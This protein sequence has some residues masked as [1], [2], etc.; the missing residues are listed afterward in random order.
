[1]KYS[2]RKGAQVSSAHLPL[3]LKYSYEM[4]AVSGSEATAQ[5]CPFH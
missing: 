2:V 1:M 4:A 3:N 5:F